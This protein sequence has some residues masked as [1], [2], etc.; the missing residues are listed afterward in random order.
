LQAWLAVRGDVPVPELFVNARDQQMSRWGFAYILRKAV[1]TASESCSSLRRKKISPH[2]LR[3]SIAMLA[4][5][6]TQDIRKVS[7]W[8]GHSSTQ[9]TEIYTRVDPTEKIEAINKLAPPKIRPGKFRPP[10]KLLAML[11]GKSLWGV[12]S[13]KSSDSIEVNARGLPI[14]N[15]SP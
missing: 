14:I 7:L 11:K 1:N 6:A 12:N 10:D 5:E 4:L 2:V 13:N 15:Y 9:T 3:H 8:L